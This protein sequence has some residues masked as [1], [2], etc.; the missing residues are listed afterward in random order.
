[1]NR[2]IV[3]LAAIIF[4]APYLGAQGLSRTYEIV[5]TNG[6][7]TS[8]IEKLV[9]DNGRWTGD[10]ATASGR[11]IWS[12][13]ETSPGMSG[14]LL[15]SAFQQKG[16][17]LPSQR[18]MFTSSGNRMRADFQIPAPRT[19]AF[20][21]RAGAFPLVNRSVATLA[22]AV[23][24]I[25]R[26]QAGSIPMFLTS[27]AATTEANVS[28]RGDTAIVLLGALESRIVLDANG[29]LILADVPAQNLRVTRITADDAARVSLRASSYAAPDGA[30][31]EATDVRISAPEGHVLA[32]TLTRPSSAGVR[33]PVV[34]T[35]SGSGP[36]DRDETLPVVSG[37]RPFR[38]IADSLGRRGVAVLRYDDRGVG[39]STGSFD[40][41]TSADFATDVRTVI[42][43]LRGRSD[44]DPDRIFLL[45]HSEGGMI[46]PMVAATD[47][48]IAGIVLLAG[49]AHTGREIIYSQQRFAIDRDTSLKSPA[50]RNAAAAR[51]RRQLNATS[52]ENNPWLG[53]LVSHDPLATARKVRAPSLV[54]QGET[55][56]Q[57]TSDQAA[58]LG[59]AL[60]AAGNTD[61]TLRVFPGLN[62]LFIADPDGDPSNYPRLSTGRVSNEVIG[63][64]VDW[65]VAR[66][67][68]TP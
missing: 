63:A 34:I 38:Q 61:V 37:F 33:V 5:Y 8:A 21:S 13:Q 57:I 35:I 20:P 39:Q 24:R 56:R 64:I 55:D 25:P 10:L 4:F 42:A 43:W 2:S 18:V 59:D 7:D 22:F 40:R 29:D 27:G 19:Q 52:Y 15:L 48:T 45:G 68:P 47:A 58:L 16:D 44:V 14:P 51:A 11:L 26:G 31:Y 30:P 53:F 12:F 32:A 3:L 23:R 65:V 41:A 67:R 36:Q 49:P 6:K 1:M 60:R 28:W 54:L 50:A 66:T 46:A 17:T 62:H 9:I